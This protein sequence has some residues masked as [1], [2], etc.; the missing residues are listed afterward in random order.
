LANLLTGGS[1]NTPLSSQNIGLTTSNVAAADQPGD[2]GSVVGGVPVPASAVTVFSPEGTLDDESDAGNV[3]N[4]SATSTWHTDSYYQQ[5]PTMKTG[6]GLLATMPSPTKL[7]SVSIN[8]STPGTRV[9]IRTSPTDAPTLDQTQI[10][11][12]STLGAGI[13]RIAVKSDQ[14][15]HYVLVWITQLGHAGSSYQSSL[16]ELSFTA[17]A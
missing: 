2:A 10:I 8:S 12:S 16:S 3:L 1:D 13:T 14:P 6:I 17:S 11:G 9:E 15:T 7:T 4:N 5:F